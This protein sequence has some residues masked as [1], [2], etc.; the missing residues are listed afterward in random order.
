MTYFK[1]PAGFFFFV[2]KKKPFPA[3]PA[4]GG[5]RLSIT[6]PLDLQGGPS[7]YASRKV[8]VRPA[9]KNYFRKPVPQGT[10]ESRARHGSAGKGKQRKPSP[11]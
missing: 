3:I 2:K 10:E 11:L 7:L 1:I 4:A 9:T 5:H 6:R 8:P